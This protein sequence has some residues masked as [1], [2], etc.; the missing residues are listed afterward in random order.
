MVQHFAQLNTY[1]AQQSNAIQRQTALSSQVANEQYQMIKIL[2][3][4]SEESFAK[5]VIVI[6]KLC[7]VLDHYE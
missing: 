1:L 3:Q 4:R 2:V 6:Q 5:L 7:A